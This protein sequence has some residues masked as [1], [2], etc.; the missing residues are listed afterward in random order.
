MLRIERNQQSL[1]IVTVSELTTITNPHYLFEF[2]EE[3]SGD[4]LYCILPNSS[5]GIPR[6]DEFLITDGLDLVFPYSGFYT[7][8]IYQQSSSTNL[9]P[10]LSDGLVEEGRAHV[11]DVDSPSNTYD[12]NVT[13]FVYE[14]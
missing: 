11:F 7:Y 4:K 8:K 3:Q 9:D 10:S 6:Y 13:N 1:L 5:N 14:Q 12:Y 2:I